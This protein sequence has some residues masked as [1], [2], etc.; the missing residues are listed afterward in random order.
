MK[1]II[2]MAPNPD[3]PFYR[4][5]L[6]HAKKQEATT[7]TVEKGLPENGRKGAKGRVGRGE[8]E[9][10]FSQ[11]ECSNATSA[12]AKRGPKPRITK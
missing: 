10:G 12:E 9:E 5:W 1:P 3:G 7:N 4:P 2:F 11:A 6:D 8:A